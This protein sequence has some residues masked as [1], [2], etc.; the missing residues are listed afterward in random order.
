MRSI[1]SY[2][3]YTGHSMYPTLREGDLLGVTAYASRPPRVGDVVVC[4]PPDA[5]E[6]VVHR[7]VSVTPRG[8]QTRGDSN[9]RIDPWQLDA[10]HIHGHVAAAWR[11]Q[12]GRAIAGGRIGLWRAA[13]SVWRW[14]HLR[15]AFSW[16]RGQ[17]WRR[18]LRGWLHAIGRCCWNPQV[19]IVQSAG[20][21]VAR[22]MLG[23]RV[24]GR[25]ARARQAWRIDWP[26]RLFIAPHHLPAR[27]D[28]EGF[29][30]RTTP[31]KNAMQ[32]SR[33]NDFV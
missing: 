29:F 20:G 15:A 6:R 10:T 21:P 2:C 16:G 32:I 7:I 22:A 12:R 25:Y 28:L 23:Q 4:T 31:Y 19:I 1:M 8:I 14:R 18:R 30:S 13:F 33:G 9:S 26:F 27:P 11:G 5:G 3:L 24:I 17:P